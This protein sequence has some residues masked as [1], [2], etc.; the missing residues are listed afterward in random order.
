MKVAA[1]AAEEIRPVDDAFARQ[2]VTFV[3]AVIVR[4]VDRADAVAD[5][6]EEVRM[7]LFEQV[8][9]I[10][11]DHDFGVVGDEP[12]KLA[13]V[14]AQARAGQVLDA[15]HRTDPFG[16]QSETADGVGG[17]LQAGFAFPV[18]DRLRTGMQHQPLRVE[19]LRQADH[20]LHQQDVLFAPLRIEHRNVERAAERQVARPFS[21][22]AEI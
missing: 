21:Q 20:P 15:E 6:L 12:H 7:L 16:G 19:D 10:E 3:L 17:V 11:A 22:L 14:A 18:G 8:V 2:P 1:Q 5:G 13:R 9:R 4:S